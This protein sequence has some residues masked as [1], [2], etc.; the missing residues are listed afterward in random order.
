MDVYFLAAL[1]TIA[2]A[3]ATIAATLLGIY[4]RLK[5]WRDGPARRRDRRKGR[6]TD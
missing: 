5:D 3:M 2:G 1:A 4:D 6:H